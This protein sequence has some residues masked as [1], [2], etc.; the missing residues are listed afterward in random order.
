VAV[1]SG[2]VPSSSSFAVA[3]GTLTAA[4]AFRPLFGRIQRAVDRRF[5]RAKYDGELTVQA[6]GTQLRYVVD[7]ATV[8]E[9][10]LAAVDRTLAPATVRLWL[11][12]AP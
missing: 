9:D 1:L 2:L 5:D 7:T 12:S 6:F 8:A 10:L 3:A 11:R 4:A